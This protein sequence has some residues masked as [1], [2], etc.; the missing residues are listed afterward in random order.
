MRDKLG[1]NYTRLFEKAFNDFE[2]SKN[3]QNAN[4]GEVS[5]NSLQSTKTVKSPNVEQ[6]TGNTEQLDDQ[7]S[8]S[9]CFVLS[10]CF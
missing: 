7:P 8:Y 5:I 1:A 6:H 9:V 2:N 4:N 10:K 3:L